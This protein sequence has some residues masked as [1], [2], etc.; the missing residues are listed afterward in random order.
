M[1]QILKY[2]R[3]GGWLWAKLA[4]LVAWLRNKYT[5]SRRV[6]RQ[7]SQLSLPGRKMLYRVQVSGPICQ[8]DRNLQIY[9][10]R[11]RRICTPV[12]QDLCVQ[13]LTSRVT[14]RYCSGDSQTKTKSGFGIAQRSAETAVNPQCPEHPCPKSITNMRLHRGLVAISSPAVTSW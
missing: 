1:W 5:L 13:P 12:S 7:K 9:S 10:R 6:V 8:S 3:V 14:I 2:V 4:Y 11:C